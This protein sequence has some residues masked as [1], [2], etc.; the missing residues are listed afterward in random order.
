MALWS[1]ES[2]SAGSGIDIVLQDYNRRDFTPLILEQKAKQK[3]FTLAFLF[4]L[5]FRP[6]SITLNSA[7]ASENYSQVIPEDFIL[8]KG[9]TNEA[10]TFQ[11]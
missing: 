9:L 1:L 6:D 3:S 8:G 7:A 5:M 4:L 2:R 11:I 10:S